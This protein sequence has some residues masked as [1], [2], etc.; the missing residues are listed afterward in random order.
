M[1][2]ENSVNEELEAEGQYPKARVS[3]YSR[4]LDLTNPNSEYG[5]KS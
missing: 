5:T 1:D 4:R 3:K 2:E